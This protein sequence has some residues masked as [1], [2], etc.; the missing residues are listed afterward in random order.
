MSEEKTE[1]KPD[2]KKDLPQKPPLTTEQIEEISK[3]VEEDLKTLDY[4]YQNYYIGMNVFRT[5][6]GGREKIRE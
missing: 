5:A 3:R 2:E 6:K 1:T 4:L